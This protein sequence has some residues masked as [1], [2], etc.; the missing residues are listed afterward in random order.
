MILDSNHGWFSELICARYDES[1]TKEVNYIMRLDFE[2]IG[3]TCSFKS[4]GDTV[5]D[6]L[7]N[8]LTIL[9]WM[10]AFM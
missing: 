9:F 8:T 6:L 4:N 7:S 3:D 5:L 10:P 2:E 1:S